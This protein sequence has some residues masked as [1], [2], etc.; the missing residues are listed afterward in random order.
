MQHLETLSAKPSE[1]QSPLSSEGN[2]EELTKQI[3][4]T[5]PIIVFPKAGG[6]SLRLSEWDAF[7]EAYQNV[8]GDAVCYRRTPT[9]GW[10]L[11][12]QGTLNWSVKQYW[13]W[14]CD[15]QREHE[16]PAIAYYLTNLPLHD[17]DR[18]AWRAQ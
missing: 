11:D 4:Q 6:G 17:V 9:D 16:M 10:K 13:S 7:Y 8:D 1:I 15:A 3:S 18:A 14:Y 5:S 12:P 2:L